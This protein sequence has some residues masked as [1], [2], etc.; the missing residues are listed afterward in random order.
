[1]IG[2]ML[3]SAWAL[4]GN[5]GLS[6]AI[7]GIETT[8]FPAGFVVPQQSITTSIREFEISAKHSLYDYKGLYFGRKDSNTI[9]CGKYTAHYYDFMNRIVIP[10]N[11]IRTEWDKGLSLF[12]DFWIDNSFYMNEPYMSIPICDD[13]SHS[14]EL[15]SNEKSLMDY[16]YKPIDIIDQFRSFLTLPD[17]YIVFLGPVSKI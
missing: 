4:I 1:M 9:I 17:S 13:P 7:Y 16:L 14:L 15:L 6:K 2:H 8:R 10:A 5:G 12:H 11:H 3:T